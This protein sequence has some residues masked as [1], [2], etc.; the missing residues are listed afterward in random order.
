MPNQSRKPPRAEGRRKALSADL[1]SIARKEV[2]NSCDDGVSPA[3]ERRIFFSLLL[4]FASSK[5]FFCPRR[6]REKSKR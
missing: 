6:M 1:A 3:A 4:S 2:V 5:G